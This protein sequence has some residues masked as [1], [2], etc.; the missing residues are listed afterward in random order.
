MKTGKRFVH[1]L[2]IGI[3]MFICLTTVP[4]NPTT[5]P[6]YSI[7]HNF[8]G[9]TTDGY[10]PYYGAPVLS[11]PTLYGMTQ[12]GGRYTTSGTLY[13]INTSG[14]GY[15]VPHWFNDETVVPAD[16]TVPRGGLTLSGSTL[17]GCTAYGGPGIGGS[18]FKMNLDGSGYTQLC[19]FAQGGQQSPYSTP[20]ISGSTLYGMTNDGDHNAGSYGGVFKVSTSGGTPEIIHNFAGKPS[21]GSRPYG[22]LTLVGSRLY[23]MTSAGGA[24]GTSGGG[25]GYGVIF[26]INTDGSDYQ[27]LHNFAGAP[28]D[29]ND[30]TGSLTLVGSKLYGMTSNGGAANGPGVIFSI[31]LDGSGYQVLLDFNGTGGAGP[32]GS[33]TLWGSM[34]YGT[35]RL[36]GPPGA[37]GS[38]FRI[39]TDGTG[40]QFLHGFAGAPSDG[41]APIGDLTLSRSG[42]TLYGYTYGGGANGAGAVFSYQMGPEPQ[43][44]GVMTLLICD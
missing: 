30:P 20:V 41:D 27:I 16:G 38:I 18:V 40:F 12:G 13:K 4:A 22:S 11:G 28:N 44:S 32:C 31:N 26:S 8:S 36:G 2:V 9:G 34:L 5:F 10:Q 37:N 23:G 19:T 42:N 29:G 24:N 21:D 3:S 15:Q 7:L 17:Y 33:L 35:T 39:N 6:V 43:L 14:S 25:A 1:G